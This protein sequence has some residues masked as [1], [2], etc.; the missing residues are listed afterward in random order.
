MLIVTI[1]LCAILGGIALD[2]WR[3]RVAALESAHRWYARCIDAQADAE[4]LA[5]A[6]SVR[7]TA[8]NISDRVRAMNYRLI[9]YDDAVNAATLAR[10]GQPDD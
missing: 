10:E 8:L 9:D 2:Q 4:R 5:V 7:A 6:R 3:R 1:T